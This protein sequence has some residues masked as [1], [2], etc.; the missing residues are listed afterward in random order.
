MRYKIIMVNNTLKHNGKLSTS[1]VLED[2]KPGRGTI[3]SKNT[4]T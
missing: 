1:I 2:Y 3:G 4:S